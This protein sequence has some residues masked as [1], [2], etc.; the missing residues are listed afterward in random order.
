MNDRWG[1]ETR[2]KHGGYYTT[3][4]DVVNNGK[5]IVEKTEH[6]WEESRGIGKSYVISLC[7]S[8]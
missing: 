3:E 5:G 2:S 6:P 1:K 7:I 4:Y 8:R